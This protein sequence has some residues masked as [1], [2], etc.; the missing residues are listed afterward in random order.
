M[1]FD[2]FTMLIGSVGGVLLAGLIMLFFWRRVPDAPW[3]KLSAICYFLIGSGQFLIVV[4]DWAPLYYS[5]AIGGAL[6]IAGFGVMWGAMRSFERRA[7]V[8]WP[9]WV[10]VGIWIAAFAFPE[11]RLSVNY[12]I[13]LASALICMLSSLTASEIWRGRKE[14]LPSRKPILG[15]FVLITAIFAV[16]ACAF[17]VYPT[18]LG[19]PTAQPIVVM[20]F[21]GLLLATAISLTVLFVSITMERNESGQRSL[22]MTDSMTG[23]SNRR[24]LET[25]FGSDTLLAQTSVIVFDLD[26]FKNVN[27]K[28][29][30]A[31]GDEVICAFADICREQFRQV[32]LAVRLGG[33]EFA[34]VLPKTSLLQAAGVAERVRKV[35]S[36]HVIGL[37][38]L[39]VACTVSAGVA[40]VGEGENTTLTDL[41]ITA[42][43]ALYRA[44]NAG[45]NRVLTPELVQAA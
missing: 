41:L 40:S 28:F 30:H 44:K 21:N 31:V 2:V 16:R 34:I 17:A 1:K 8:H 26:H 10:C 19:G 14:L 43:R 37:D 7:F 3:F 12:K 22:A 32:D 18:P 20:V 24:D 5:V 15:I 9:V 11:F 38:D 27:D 33:E 25:R 39:A 35:F 23:L 4:R 13:V 6:A 42:D 29:G 36:E 45:R